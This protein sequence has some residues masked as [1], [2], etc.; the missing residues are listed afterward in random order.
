MKWLTFKVS[1]ARLV[2]YLTQAFSNLAVSTQE[3]IF[4]PRDSLENIIPNVF[5]QHLLSALHVFDD[6]RPDGVVGMVLESM[7]VLHD[8]SPA[9]F[10]LHLHE[11]CA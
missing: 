6:H 10:V 11:N 4:R 1:G 3:G 9:L 7:L 5:Y 8:A 2:S